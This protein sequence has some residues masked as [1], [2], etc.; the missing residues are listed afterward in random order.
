VNLILINLI[1]FIVNTYNLFYSIFN[2]KYNYIN[3]K[4]KIEYTNTITPMFSLIL[5]NLN[6]IVI[7]N[8]TYN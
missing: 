2:I 5:Y 3:N 4:I 6:K 7:T 1:K 8:C